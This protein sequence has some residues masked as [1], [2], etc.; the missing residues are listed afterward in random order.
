[1]D[2]KVNPVKQKL[3]TL[4]PEKKNAALA[5]INK[6]AKNEFI[7]K[8]KYPRWLSNIVM[9]KKFHRNLENVHRFHIV[10][11]ILPKG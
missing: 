2:S 1:M 5:E 4:G 8:I 6:L 11:Q 7:R 9:V 3:R 10:G